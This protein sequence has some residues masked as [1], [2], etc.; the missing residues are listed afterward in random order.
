MPVPQS[1]KISTT[2][3]VTRVKPEQKTA[4]TEKVDYFT[5]FQD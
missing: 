3:L 4:V 5:I 1:I 2:K